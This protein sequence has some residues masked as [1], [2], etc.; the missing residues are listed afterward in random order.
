MLANMNRVTLDYL[1]INELHEK[2]EE[3]EMGKKWSVVFV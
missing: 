3:W 1:C 2:H